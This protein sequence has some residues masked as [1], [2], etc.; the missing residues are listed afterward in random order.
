MNIYF[1]SA[2]ANTALC[3]ECDGLNTL[4]NKVIDVQQPWIIEAMMGVILFLLNDCKT[5]HY[6]RKYVRIE[7][8]SCQ[9]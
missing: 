9:K 3:A 7:V 2:I 8:S 1:I 5:R 4:V 6:I